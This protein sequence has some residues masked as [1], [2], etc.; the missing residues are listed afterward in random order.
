MQLEQ[1]Y[2]SL[3]AGPFMKTST[4]AEVAKYMAE[5]DTRQNYQVFKGISQSPSIVELSQK[6]GDKYGLP[7]AGN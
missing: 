5:K 1:F 4:K 3:W 2:D 7:V 6:I